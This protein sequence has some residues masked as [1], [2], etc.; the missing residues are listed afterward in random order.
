MLVNSLSEFFLPIPLYLLVLLCILCVRAF[1]HPNT[2]LRRLRYWFVA[3]VVWSY[4]FSTPGLANVLIA[5]LES[6]YPAVDAPTAAPDPLIVVLSGGVMV[7]RRTG[8]FE[9]R[10]DPAGW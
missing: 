6:K 7:K 9:V 1:R 10:L 5:H 2:R 3:L 8:H 4:L